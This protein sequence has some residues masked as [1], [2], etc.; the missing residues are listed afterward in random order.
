MLCKFIVLLALLLA[1]QAA[2][3]EHLVPKLPGY[4]GGA[5]PSKHYSGYIPTGSISGS[6]GQ[7]HYWFIESTNNPASDPVVLWLNGG[8]G[9]SSLIGLLTENGQVVTNDDSLTEKVDG[10]P[11]VFLNTYAWSKYANVVY[12][13]SPK[14][15][16]F[17]YCEGVTKS[18]D[19]VNTDES[20]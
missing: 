16:G 15:V 1:V 19:C 12:L 3:Q 11:Q 17:S 2:I 14:G 6:K 7:L 18:S 8:P 20:T 5:P 4:K 9:S 10:V 13:E